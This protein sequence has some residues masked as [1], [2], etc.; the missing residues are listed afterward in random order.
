[1]AAVAELAQLAFGLVAIARR[2]VV[3][4]RSGCALELRS[5]GAVVARARERATR[6]RAGE[7]GLDRRA[8]G[9]G[10]RRRRASRPIP[11]FSA[12]LRLTYTHPVRWESFRNARR[13]SEVESLMDTIFPFNSAAS[14]VLV[15]DAIASAVA[16]NA[17]PAAVEL[18]AEAGITIF[19]LVGE[20]DLSDSHLL[21][22][23]LRSAG[24]DARVLVDLSECTYMDLSVVGRLIR[25]GN[26]LRARGGRLELLI[27]PEANA[28]WPSARRT[29]LAASL[30]THATRAAAIASLADARDERAPDL[31][32]PG[33]LRRLRHAG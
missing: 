20:H 16:K 7:G 17:A 1:M 8:R 30:K 5:R 13:S 31:R 19:K 4:E 15:R 18:D 11:T 24:E 23:A 14:D 9:L 33:F 21:A 26:R 27:P 22:A 2:A 28:M 32:L 3:V 29:G 12:R 25:A 10:G 6:E